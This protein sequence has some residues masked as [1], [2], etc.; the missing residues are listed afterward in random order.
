M[1]AT[2]MRGIGRNTDRKISLLRKLT[3][4]SSYRYTAGGLEKT[5]SKPKP[6]TLPSLETLKR[7][8]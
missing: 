8:K 5:R 3:T 7:I 2:R 6:V 1:T 4:T